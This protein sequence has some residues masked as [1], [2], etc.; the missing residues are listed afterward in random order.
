MENVEVS[1]Y[2][3]FDQ[4]APDS[5]PV[6]VVY[7]DINKSGATATLTNGT[8]GVGGNLS[9]CDGLSRLTE[10]GFNISGD[11]YIPADPDNPLKDIT[12]IDLVYRAGNTQSVANKYQF[13]PSYEAIERDVKFNDDAISA[14]TG[15][16][17][18]DLNFDDIESVDRGR[19][20]KDDV[21]NITSLTI[22]D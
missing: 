20:T 14:F 7:D 1:T 3:E 11:K 4:Y 15:E 6:S 9:K 16:T 21:D 5:S 12:G 10:K 18:N 19:V 13:I 17:A 8:V 2:F 22:K